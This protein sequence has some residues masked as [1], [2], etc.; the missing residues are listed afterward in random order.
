MPE[1]RNMRSGAERGRQ[2]PAAPPLGGDAGQGLNSR[3]L[4]LADLRRLRHLSFASRRVVEGQYAGRHASSVRGHSVEFN[5]Y[6]QYM[7]GDEAGDIDWKVY[8][9]SDKM[10]IK[11]FEHQSDMSVNLLLDASASM[12]YRGLQRGDSKYDRACRLAAAVAFLTTNQQDQVSFALAQGGL[13]DFFRPHGS[14]GHFVSILRTMESA[15]PGGQAGLPGA[16]R[17]MATLIGRRGLLIVFSDLLD[18]PEEIFNA[19][20]IFTHRGSEVILFHV[21]HADELR[22]PPLDQ[23]LFID[24][25]TGRSLSTNVADVRAA[26]ERKLANYLSVWSSNCKG[27]GIDYKLVSTAADYKQALAEYLFQRASMD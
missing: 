6:R 23:A 19:L 21:L 17:Q 24:S 15:R 13:R 9:R 20:A 16:L 1:S 7:P 5:D 18:E 27:R 11:L 12:S 22:L 14:F 8:G 3:Y 26:Y 2:R 25:E 10:F 4:R